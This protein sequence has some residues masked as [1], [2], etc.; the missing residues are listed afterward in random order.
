MSFSRTVPS[1]ITET[2][3]IVVKVDFSKLS[4]GE[5]HRDVTIVNLLEKRPCELFSEKVRVFS[6]NSRFVWIVSKDTGWKVN[7]S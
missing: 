4:S 1:K 3:T 2:E 6:G 5:S 7:F